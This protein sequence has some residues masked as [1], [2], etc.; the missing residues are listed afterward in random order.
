MNTTVQAG[1]NKE[2]LQWIIVPEQAEKFLWTLW[3]VLTHC[4]VYLG[5]HA[6]GPCG[7]QLQVSE[8]NGASNISQPPF[9]PVP[10]A[11][12]WRRGSD[13]GFLVVYSFK[14]QWAFCQHTVDV[15]VNVDVKSEAWM[16]QTLSWTAAPAGLSNTD[17]SE[18][19]QLFWYDINLA[20]SSNG[21]DEMGSVFSWWLMMQIT[22]VGKLAHVRH[23]G[24]TQNLP[25]GRQISL[26]W[27][28]ETA[29]G[30]QCPPETPRPLN[31][32][33]CKNRTVLRGENTSTEVQQ[34]SWN[35]GIRLSSLGDSSSWTRLIHEG[36]MKNSTKQP[37]SEFIPG[38]VILSGSDHLS[39]LHFQ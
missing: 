17:P 29:A 35:S 28:K 30:S 4:A 22:A 33:V 21:G 10:E 16:L 25:E 7:L 24:S 2:E 1:W 31:S 37:I 38:S 3:H 11:V 18:A 26:C 32:T 13:D 23:S 19:A 39:S 36:L 6:V 14:P 8:K 9:K 15:S 34:S 27:M 5:H 12:L 20:S